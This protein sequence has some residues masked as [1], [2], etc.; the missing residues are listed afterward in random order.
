MLR[1]DGNKQEH[2]SQR[3]QTDGAYSEKG[4][5]AGLL[6][7]RILFKPPT[8]GRLFPVAEHSPR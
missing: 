6:D 4:E 1:P 5:P 7:C 3:A 2:E 8:L